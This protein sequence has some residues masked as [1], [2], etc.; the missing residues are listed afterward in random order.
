MLAEF[1]NPIQLNDV[2]YHNYYRDIINYKY[3]WSTDFDQFVGIPGIY[4]GER[5]ILENGV[6]IIQASNDYWHTSIY[7]SIIYVIVIFSIKALMAKREKGFELKREL[8][9]WNFLLALFSF[10][11]VIR[12]L[13]EF[14]QILYN[15]GFTAS[16]TENTYVEVSFNLFSF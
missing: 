10:V 13:P 9:A 2:R 1:S 6:E 11:G 5:W 12:C 14:V 15:K 4:P 7:L 8:V 16:Y 3:N